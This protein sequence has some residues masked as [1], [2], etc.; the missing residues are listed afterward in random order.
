MAE[1]Q[2]SLFG[3]GFGGGF[4]FLGLL[5]LII[6]GFQLRQGLKT[7]DWPVT[8][9]SIVESKIVEEKA[10]GSSGR[11]RARGFDMKYTVHVRYSYEVN[12]QKF[13]SD[14]LRYGNESHDSR[15]SANDEQL[16]YSPGKAVQVYYDPMSPHQSVLIKGIGLSWLAMALGLM[17]LVIGLSVMFHMARAK[18]AQ[19]R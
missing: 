8:E 12:G 9:G 19:I 18:T 2:Q 1:K 16:L 11:R 7:N 4:T 13:E 14:R 3:W 15:A 17:G 5:F 10:S 6:G